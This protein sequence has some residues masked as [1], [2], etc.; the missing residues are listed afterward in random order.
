MRG[1]NWPVMQNYI[2]GGCCYS[3]LYVSFMPAIKLLWV[4]TQL[5]HQAVAW[6]DGTEWCPQEFHD[7][8]EFLCGSLFFVRIWFFIWMAATCDLP[9]GITPPC[10]QAKASKICNFFHHFQWLIG[11]MKY[12]WEV[13]IW[14]ANWW[15]LLWC[16]LM[17]HIKNLLILLQITVILLQI[18]W[19]CA[20][21]GSW[22][23]WELPSQAGY[24]TQ[25]RLG[26][27]WQLGCRPGSQVAS[28]QSHGAAYLSW[29]SQ[30]NMRGWPSFAWL[31]LAMAWVLG[32]APFGHPSKHAETD[33][34]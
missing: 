9:T 14:D 20:V 21:G 16:K 30:P 6:D 27:W 33:P 22:D 11:S 8:H 31:W 5:Q 3:L 17:V 19:W 4:I 2:W 29:A 32:R 1:W 7:S 10:P 24:Q 13:D 34:A 28:K 26:G 25:P 12:C 15:L 23:A 18:C